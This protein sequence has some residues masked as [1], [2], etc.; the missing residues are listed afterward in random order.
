MCTCHL[1]L[2][3][4]EVTKEMDRRARNL[5]RAVGT[6]GMGKT[7]GAKTPAKEG[8]SALKPQ[9]HQHLQPWLLSPIVI[10]ISHNFTLH[11]KL[12]SILFPATLSVTTTIT[13]VHGAYVQSTT[14]VERAALGHLFFVS[15]DP[16][17]LHLPLGPSTGWPRPMTMA[18][19]EKL[20]VPPDSFSWE[21]ERGNAE[22]EAAGMGGSRGWRGHD[23]P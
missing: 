9:G 2:R 4:R 19:H 6:E 5:C 23:R 3:N 15:C 16:P 20:R 14:R 18:S 11:V 17:P 22:H 13:I 10:V 1:Y 21:S 12:I 7:G 8:S